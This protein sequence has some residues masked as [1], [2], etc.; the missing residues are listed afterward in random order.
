MTELKTAAD[1]Y[2]RANLRL[3][4]GLLIV[5]FAVSSAVEYCSLTG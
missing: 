2:W 3:L 5:W 1:A 4:A